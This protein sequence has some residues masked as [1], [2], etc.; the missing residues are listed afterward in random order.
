MTITDASDSPQVIIAGYGLPG[1]VVAERLSSRGVAHCVI[2]LNPAT[3]QRCVKAGT[4]IIAGNCA[5]PQVLIRA[6]I[7]HAKTFIVVV[8]DEAAALEATRHARQIN[9]SLF[10]ITRCYYTSAGIQAKS[11][12]ADEVIVAEQVVADEVLRRTAEKWPPPSPASPT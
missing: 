12:G 11:L 4:S 6:G 7:E 5:D 9:P 3:V 8:P 1:R 10:I 2:E